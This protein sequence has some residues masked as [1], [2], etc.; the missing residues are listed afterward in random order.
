MVGIAHYKGFFER[1][2]LPWCKEQG[3]LLLRDLDLEEVTKFRNSLDNRGTVRNRKVSRLRSFFNFCRMRRWIDENPAEF[4]K[5]SQEQEPQAEYLQP[6][7]YR[8]LLD[9]CYVSH[10]WERGHDFEHRPDRMRAF[11]LFARWTGLAMI[12]VVRFRRD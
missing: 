9:A 11:L 1:Q 12:D 4:I 3:I 2:L 6:K 10:K 5:P 8:R 7:E